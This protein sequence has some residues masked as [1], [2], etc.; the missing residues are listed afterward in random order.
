MQ[1]RKSNSISAIGD[2]GYTLRKHFVQSSKRS[3][4]SDPAWKLAEQAKGAF[5]RPAKRYAES[6]YYFLLRNVPQHRVVYQ[7]VTS[8][9]AP[10]AAWFVAVLDPVRSDMDSKYAYTVTGVKF[11]SGHLQSRIGIGFTNHVLNRLYQG[12]FDQ[13]D[14]RRA[15]DFFVLVA[16]NL[17]SRWPQ[18]H[19][20]RNTFTIAVRGTDCVL[21]GD[22]KRNRVSITAIVSPD[23]YTPAQREYLAQNAQTRDT[24]FMQRSVTSGVVVDINLGLW[25]DSR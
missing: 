23:L 8:L 14:Q 10:H 19:A 1:H 9:L 16:S 13:V 12:V 20:A 17:M 24:F 6:A 7:D 3:E 22:S 18:L 2:I 25:D 5:S 15:E 21:I 4:G 11:S